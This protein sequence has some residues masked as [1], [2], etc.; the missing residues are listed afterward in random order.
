[1]YESLDAGVPVLG[2]TFFNDQPRNIDNLVN[3][4]MAIGMD[5]LS[6]TED[7]LLNAI[8]EIVNNDRWAIIVDPSMTR[9]NYTHHCSYVYHRY[10]KNA[11]IVSER[12]KDRPMSPAKSVVYWTEYVLRHKGAPHLKSQALDLTWYQYFLIDVISTFLFTA[13][14]LF[15]IIYYGLKMTYKHIFKYFHMASVKCA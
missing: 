6:I 1:M 10:Q 3:A 14:V 15:L 7:T 11:K 9:K 12:F 8:L 5:L 4:G 2:F 13:F